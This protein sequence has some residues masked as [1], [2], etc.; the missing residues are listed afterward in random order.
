[1]DGPRPVPPT[2]PQRSNSLEKGS[3][4]LRALARSPSYHE[5]IMTSEGPAV[6]A[7]A[8]VQKVAS[9]AA[10]S[11]EISTW[12]LVVNKWEVPRKILH[13]SIGFVVL[14]LY[15]QH[16]D[17]DKIVRVL[18]YMFLFVSSA[19]LLRLN[20]PAFERIYEFVLGFLM[21]E[22]EKERVNGVVFYLLGVIVAL[23]LF[24]EDIGCISIIIL[25]WCDPSASTF[26]RIFGRSTPSLP[27][28]PFARRK[29]LAGFIAASIMG[30]FVAY[31][32]W[33]TSIGRIGERPSRLSWT[34]G[35]FS[36]FG[37]SAPGFL[38]TGWTGFSTGFVSRGGASTKPA[39]PAWL[40]YTLCGLISG[41]TEALDLGGI[42]DN[43][44][45]PILA[46]FGI[47]AVL[48]VWG[49]FV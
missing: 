45:I 28:P 38:H 8:P 27:S 7:A 12:D 3:A 40:L 46:G 17:L 1:M 49:L 6:A 35:G 26:G 11:T 29:S 20:V 22:G 24:P 34:P 39:I 2:Q 47:W 33:G 30:V 9:K 23:K 31:M 36:H 43:M 15:F 14:Y 48:W 10:P 44:S 13:C 25:S 16:V 18:F 21:R 4:V 5:A 19:D 37:T 42:D 32:F 41:V